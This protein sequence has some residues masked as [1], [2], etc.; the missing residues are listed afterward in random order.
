MFYALMRESKIVV[1][2]DGRAYHFD[3]LSNYDINTS[4][5]EFKTLRRTIHRRTNYA[6]SIIN[7]QTPSSISLAINFSNTLTE[8]NFFEWMGFDREGNTFLLPLYSTNIE[9]TMFNIYIVNKDNNCV[10]FENCYVSTVDFSLDKSVPILNVGIESG[11]FSEVSTFNPAGSIVQGEVI[12]YSPPRVSTNSNVLPALLSAS[13]SFQQQ[14]SWRED[15]SVFDINKIYNNKR[16]YVNEM[17]A[18]ATI[19]FYYTKRFAGDM[20]YNIEPETDIP[21]TIRNEHISIDFP[22]ARITKRLQFSDIYRVEWDVIPTADSDP[23]RIDFFGEIK[24]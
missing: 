18:S 13:M 5:E 8:A 2:Y 20:F 12:S 4:Y 19:A 21:L 6:D 9:P 14:C 17:N 7:A 22:S 10:Y 15:K 16:A 11:K 1:E 3:A 24:K 23:V